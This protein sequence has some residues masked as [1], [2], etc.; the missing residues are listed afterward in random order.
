MQPPDPELPLDGPLWR[1]A[2]R[3]YGRPGVAQACLALQQRFDADVNLLL[4]AAWL[5]AERGVA[6]SAPLSRQAQRRVDAWHEDIVRPLRA[7]RQR[8]KTGPAPAPCGAT[9]ALRDALKAVEIG[10]ERIEL[11]VLETLAPE[12]LAGRPETDLDAVVRS[13]LRTV[14]ALSAREDLFAEAGRPVRAIA[15]AALDVTEEAVPCGG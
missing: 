15:R 4:F 11:A 12:A 3:V 2:T 1:F 5:G 9:E 7:V 10:S 13:N 14:L 8:M 6:L